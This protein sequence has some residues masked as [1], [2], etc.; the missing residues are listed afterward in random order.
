[1][2]GSGSGVLSRMIGRIFPLDH[3]VWSVVGLGP[4]MINGNGVEG[5]NILTFSVKGS[6]K[7]GVK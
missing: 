6:L 5:R 4:E 3:A 7:G 1:M 2:V